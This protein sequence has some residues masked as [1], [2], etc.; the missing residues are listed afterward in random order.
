MYAATT[1][2]DQILTLGEKEKYILRLANHKS[3]S[4]EQ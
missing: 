3:I 4:F 2:P 1:K